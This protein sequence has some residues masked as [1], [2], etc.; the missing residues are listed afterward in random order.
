MYNGFVKNEELVPPV[1]L[2]EQSEQTF[3]EIATMANRIAFVNKGVIL[4]GNKHKIDASGVRVVTGAEI[5]ENKALG[6]DWDV[7]SSLI[8]IYPCS[9]SA[10]E[11]N[12][13]SVSIADLEVVGNCPINL[14]LNPSD[15]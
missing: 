4:N 15:P 12:T 10:T 13:Y 9:G 6:Y 3:A 14:D 11:L 5:S 1:A 2:K 8:G 7:H